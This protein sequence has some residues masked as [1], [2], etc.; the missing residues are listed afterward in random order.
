LC[1]VDAE[2]LLLIPGANLFVST[3]DLS[4]P[5]LADGSGGIHCRRIDAAHELS[6]AQKGANYLW[7]ILIGFAGA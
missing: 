3:Q 5:P 7:R 6:F 1:S 2:P 4:R